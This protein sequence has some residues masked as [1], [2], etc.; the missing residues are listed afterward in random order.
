M[1]TFRPGIAARPLQSRGA[2]YCAVMIVGAAALW[3]PASA[4][5]SYASYDQKITQ[6]IAGTL[7]EFD[8]N[9]PHSGVTVAYTNS[10]GAIDEVSVTTGSPAVI[11]EQGFKPKDFKVGM[12]VT[13]SWHPNRNGV[14]GGELI[15]LQMEDG[16]VLHGGFPTT[17]G[18][19]KG[20]VSPPAGAPTD[21]ARP[22]GT[23]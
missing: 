23:G 16:R 4:H 3:R 2:M 5:H 8:W 19:E 17:P 1:K 18:A 11:S 7:K 14:P 9:A 15:E 13:M 21:L 12:K 10:Q 20:A 6:T 22:P